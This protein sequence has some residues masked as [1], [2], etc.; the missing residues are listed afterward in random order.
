MGLELIV[1]DYIRRYR[2]SAQEEL[3]WFRSQSDLPTAVDVAARAVNREG[4]R[5]SHQY[6]IRADSIRS[7]R[8][9]L[10]RDLDRIKGAANFGVLVRTIKEILNPTDGVRCTSTTAPCVS[11]RSLATCQSRSFF[12]PGRETVRGRWG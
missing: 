6:K 11:V 7:A 4:K 2:T 5:Y 12:T 3:E 9:R 1:D 8:Q 10:A